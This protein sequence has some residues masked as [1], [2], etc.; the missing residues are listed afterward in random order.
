MADPSAGSAASLDD[1]AVA[2]ELSASVYRRF[3]RGPIHDCRRAPEAIQIAVHQ[4][5]EK[6]SE[7]FGS[8][9]KTSRLSCRRDFD[10]WRRFRNRRRCE[11]QQRVLKCSQLLRSDLR[12]PQLQFRRFANLTNPVLA[13]RCSRVLLELRALSC[14]GMVPFATLWPVFG[15]QQITYLTCADTPPLG[16]PL[17]KYDEKTTIA[18]APP[19]R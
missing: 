1:R 12:P 15:R 5:V 14:S 7:P 8:K 2:P 17:R 4:S 6:T 19:F 9:P 10:S 11:L 13:H 16:I 18:E 3:G